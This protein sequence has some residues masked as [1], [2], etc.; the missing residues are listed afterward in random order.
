MK[1]GFK[2]YGI[3][4]LLAVVLFNVISFA[5]PSTVMIGKFE[6]T[7]WVGY[8]FV[9]IAFIGQAACSYK[10]FKDTDNSNK[11]FLNL[12]IITVSY[13]ALIVSTV[14]GVL[15][16]IIPFIPVWIGAILCVLI[17]VIYATAIVK[18][19]AV[20]EIVSD[21]DNKIKEKTLFIKSLTIDLETLE[22]KAK[23]ADIVTYR[24][25]TGF[26]AVLGYL[27]MTDQ[28]KRLE[29]L[30]DWC[31]VRVEGAHHDKN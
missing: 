24:M 3:V 30:I 1:K 11:V 2:Y 26:E 12:P 8:I 13:S 15:C 4:W 25:S 14:V 6:G 7:Y 23:N 28:I 20:G 27:H 16:M 29:E 18:A 21:I 22:M 31:I 10:F 17:F 5:I 9:M 19:T